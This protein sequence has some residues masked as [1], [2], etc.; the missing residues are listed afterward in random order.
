MSKT[1]T[2]NNVVGAEKESL[3]MFVA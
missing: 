3:E 1:Q 2:A